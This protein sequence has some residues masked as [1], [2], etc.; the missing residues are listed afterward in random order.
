MAVQKVWDA[1]KDSVRVQ[2]FALHDM[3]NQ[4]G[5]KV[6]VRKILKSEYES[7]LCKDACLGSVNRFLWP[8]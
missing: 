4:S 6:D 5:I 1:N 2:T 7:K 3:A 8:R